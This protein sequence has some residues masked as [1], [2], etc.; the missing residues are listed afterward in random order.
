[1][2]LGS[3]GKGLYLRVT[4]PDEQ[5]FFRRGWNS[6]GGGHHC[7]MWPLP[8]AERIEMEEADYGHA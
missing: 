2:Y 4:D 7:W 1:M 3:R 6:I 8:P 5:E